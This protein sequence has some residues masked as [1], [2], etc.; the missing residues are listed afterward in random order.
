MNNTPEDLEQL[1]VAC[2]RPDFSHV[3]YRRWC[4]V[5]Q[6]YVYVADPASPSGCS[7]LT[8]CTDDEAARAVLIEEGKQA[9]AGGQQGHA[10]CVAGMRGGA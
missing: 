6:L 10:A 9:Q 5:D 2:R 1:R 3:S 4:G 7:Y 8:G